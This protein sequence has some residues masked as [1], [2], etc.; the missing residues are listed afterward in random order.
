MLAGLQRLLD[1]HAGRTVVVV[2]HVTPIK[3]LVAHA[4]DAPLA[5]VFRME[6][7]PASVSVVSFFRGGKDGSEP[8]ASLRMFN[9]LPPGSD[10]FAGGAGSPPRLV[11]GVAQTSRDDHVELGALA[12][13]RR[14]P[15]PPAEVAQQVGQRA[16]GCAGRRRP[17][18][19]ARTI[20]PLVALLK[21]LTTCRL[22]FDLV[23]HPD[24]GH[25]RREVGRR[26]PERG[27]RR[28]PEVD[29]QPARRAPR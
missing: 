2:S 26:P 20:R 27:V 6:L 17:P 29:Q 12:R 24:G 5:A 11:A 3:T 14:R 7:S 22:P 21:W 16:P 28:G 9:A 13:R 8:R 10:A 15:R 19:A 25:P 4:V 23:Q 1:A 18:A